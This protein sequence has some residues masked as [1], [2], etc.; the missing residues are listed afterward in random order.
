M[1]IGAD[2]SHAAPGSQ[3]ASFAAFTVS[4]DAACVRYAAAVETNGVRVE[5]IATRNIEDMLRPLLMEWSMNTGQ[6]QL[7]KHVYYF[8][9]GVSEGQYQNV[10]KQEVA[11]MKRLMNS[12]GQHN[13][14]LDVSITTLFPHGSLL[15]GYR[16][17]SLWWWLRNDIISVSSR[18]ALQQLIRTATPFLAHW[19]RRM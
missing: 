11:D 15:T 7:P 8:R 14:N 6:G 5:M 2:V 16:S 4:M 1:I 3:A 10:L 13:K 12:I 19:S 18:K 9:D 17:S